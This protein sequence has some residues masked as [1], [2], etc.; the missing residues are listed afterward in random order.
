[1]KLDRYQ[2]AIIWATKSTVVQGNNTNSSFSNSRLFVVCQIPRLSMLVHAVE[3]SDLDTLPTHSEIARS[4]PENTKTMMKQHHH[5][6]IIIIATITTI[7]TITIIP[8]P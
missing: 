8:T 5:H 4:C 3:W 1:V 6:H 2:A 7:I